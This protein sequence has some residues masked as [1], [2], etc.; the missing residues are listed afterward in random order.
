MKLFSNE[1]LVGKGGGDIYECCFLTYLEISE[2][3]EGRD[4]ER[5]WDLWREIIAEKSEGTEPL[6]RF[7]GN[8]PEGRKKLVETLTRF[9]ARFH[10]PSRKAFTVPPPSVD[11][12]EETPPPE[13]PF[14]AIGTLFGDET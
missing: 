12:A 13:A 14:D 3:A 5:I 8:T 10:L 6:N 2:L 7:F 9:G 11:E 4:P 1:F